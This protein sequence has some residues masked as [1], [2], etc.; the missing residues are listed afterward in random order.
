MINGFELWDGV[1][2]PRL[3]KLGRNKDKS[4]LARRLLV[5]L[6]KFSNIDFYLPFLELY[7]KAKKKQIKKGPSEDYVLLDAVRDGL[8]CHLCLKSG[9]WTGAVYKML[10]LSSV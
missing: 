7:R 6:S 10:T 1:C 2:G 3:R 4:E 9:N 8:D 5:C